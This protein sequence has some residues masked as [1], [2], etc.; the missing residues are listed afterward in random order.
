[1]TTRIDWSCFSD[2]EIEELGLPPRKPV[3]RVSYRSV[4]GYSKTRTFKTLKSARRFAHSWV[5]EHPDM[6][7]G[8]AVSY[9][10]VGRIT[11]SGCRLID[12]FPSRID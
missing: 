9:D 7:T 6:G 1:M 10:G 4:D 5:G 3:I 11:V 2:Q 12:L 8:Y